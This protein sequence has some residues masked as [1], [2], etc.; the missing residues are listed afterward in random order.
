MERKPL[1][2][3]DPNHDRNRLPVMLKGSKGRSPT[4]NTFDNF[5]MI[6]NRTIIR[7]TF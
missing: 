1:V 2:P 7:N 5:E 4:K 6:K 3:Y